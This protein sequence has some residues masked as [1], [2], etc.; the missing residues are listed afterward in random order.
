MRQRS[1]QFALLLTGL[2]LI[3]QAQP[4]YVAQSMLFES[5]SESLGLVTS[6]PI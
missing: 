6:T 4:G 2:P 3:G 5:L 1:L